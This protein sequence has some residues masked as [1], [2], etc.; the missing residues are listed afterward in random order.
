MRKLIPPLIVVV[1]IIA[2]VLVYGNLP[3]SM[4]THWNTDGDVNGWSSRAF[5]AFLIPV[6]L[7]FFWLLMRF[8]PRIDPRGQN[9]AKF[10]GA[11]EGM[12]I[13]FMLFLLGVHVIVLRAAL[14][15]H[16]QM[17]RVVPI[18]IGALFVVL[19]FFLPHTQPNWF[20]GI[21]TP[22]TL[23]SDVV[24]EKTHRLGGKVFVG[25]GFLIILAAMIAP[26]STHITMF[27]LIAI[28]VGVLLVYSYR[29]WKRE[30]SPRHPAYPNAG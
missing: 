7:A 5:G 15:Y 20:V 12:I 23:S 27:A 22:W 1:A 21:R 29:E 10:R 28:S 25:A 8:V 14:G 24:W 2:S 17:Q 11:F 18:A 4:P 13:A 30:G 19:G 16:V 9:F 3:P 6:M 26:A